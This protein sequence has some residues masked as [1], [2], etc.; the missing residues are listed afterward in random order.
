MCHPA[1]V[2][3]AEIVHFGLQCLVPFASSCSQSNLSLKSLRRVQVLPW[4]GVSQYNF[5]WWEF[6]N[7]IVQWNS[8]FPVFPGLSTNSIDLLMAQQCPFPTPGSGGPC[9]TAFRLCW[10]IWQGTVAQKTHTFS[11][12][13]FFNIFPRLNFHQLFL[14]VAHGKHF[15]F[16]EGR[17]LSASIFL[18]VNSTGTTFW[19]HLKLNLSQNSTT[20]SLGWLK[21]AAE[22]L[23]ACLS[24]QYIPAL[25]N[26][27]TLGGNHLYVYK[28][29][30][31]GWLTPLWCCPW[32]RVNSRRFGENS[33]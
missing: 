3:M 20:S 6:S 33:D 8:S 28:W 13:F 32:V 31:W 16:R 12:L 10:V 17:L 11:V 7:F 30:T 22:R 23:L 2:E 18:K 9:G 14:L 15:C 27:L 5:V 29:S 26:C 21:S 4:A 25:E 24:F 1:L 19:K